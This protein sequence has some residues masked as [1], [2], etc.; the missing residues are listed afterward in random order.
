MGWHGRPHVPARYGLH[1]WRALQE[2]GKDH[3]LCLYGTETMHVLRAEK[4]FIIVGQD[5][6]GTVTPMDLGMNWIV[7][8]KKDDFL[9]RR[10]FSRSDTKR[11]GRKQLVGL[12]TQNP[13]FILPEG[14]HVVEEVKP[15]P[16]MKTL[17]HVTSSYYSPNV[18]RSIALALV[19]DGH[20][21]K[22]ETLSVPMMNGR[23]E[24]VTIT[25]TVFFDKE[26][27]RSNG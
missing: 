4:G 15:K 14:A 16:P 26:G 13:N 20:N 3:D 8:K 25:E 1:V 9:G 24:K 2:A 12:L 19:A 18:G 6:D 17:G 7:S 22:G 21:R 23:V 5:T 10:S 11:E 27:V